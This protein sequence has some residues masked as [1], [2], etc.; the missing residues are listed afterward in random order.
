[1]ITST[2]GPYKDESFSTG[3]PKKK[4][5]KKAGWLRTFSCSY[6][7]RSSVSA[8]QSL[9]P[10][11][12]LP[13]NPYVKYN[14]ISP[15]VHLQMMLHRPISFWVHNHEWHSWKIRSWEI[16][17]SLALYFHRLINFQSLLLPVNTQ[18]TINHISNI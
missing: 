18:Q 15:Q 11:Q 14:L 17:W 2:E 9:K 6:Q 1:M 10:Q 4:K 13:S 12:S 5:K 3:E 8:M 7:E 16:S